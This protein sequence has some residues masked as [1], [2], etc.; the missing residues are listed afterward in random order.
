VQYKADMYGGQ[1]EDYVKWS[2]RSSKKFSDGTRFEIHSVQNMVTG[3]FYELKTN[4]YN[5]M[6]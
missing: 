2:S 4:I 6:R 3:K 5:W 1:A